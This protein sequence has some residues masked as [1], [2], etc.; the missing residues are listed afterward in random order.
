MATLGLCFRNCRQG[1]YN[2]QGVPEVVLRVCGY[3]QVPTES[4]ITVK[5]GGNP[6]HY[7]TQCLDSTRWEGQK[8]KETGYLG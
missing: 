3:W 7:Q 8:H 4:L 1:I 5:I 6:L 2:R